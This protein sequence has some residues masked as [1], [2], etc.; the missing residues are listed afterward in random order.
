[1]SGQGT[2][3][4][5]SHT[6]NEDTANRKSPKAH[7][8]INFLHASL[9]CHDSGPFCNLLPLCLKCSLLVLFSKPENMDSLVFTWPGSKHQETWMFR[10]ASFTDRIEELQTRKVSPLAWDVLV[11][12]RKGEYTVTLQETMTMINS[13]WTGR[14]EETWDIFLHSWKCE[15]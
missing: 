5:P 4:C 2:I 6:D 14:K 12:E 11:V 15:R 9:S 8:L 1:M 7:I 13:H 3:D 10:L